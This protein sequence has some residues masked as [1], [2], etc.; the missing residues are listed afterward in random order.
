MLLQKAIHVFGADGNRVNSVDAAVAAL[1][2]LMEMAEDMTGDRAKEAVMHVLKQFSRGKSRSVWSVINNVAEVMIDRIMDAQQGKLSLNNPAAEVSDV[3]SVSASMNPRVRAV[4][5]VYAQIKKGANDGMNAADIAGLVPRVM[6]AIEATRSVPTGEEKANIAVEVLEQLADD[7][8]ISDKPA[9]KAVLTTAKAA[10]YVYSRASKGQYMLNL[11]GGAA[12]L[13]EIA[14]ETM[15]EIGDNVED[16]A[17][18]AASSCCCPSMFWKQKDVVQR[19]RVRLGMV[20][21]ADPSWGEH[22][23]L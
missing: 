17:G 5:T 3:S 16:L 1:P 7:A 6:E 11:S 23:K 20:R 18:R 19:R 2:H 10:M 8:N 14:A 21:R 4:L 15:A 12:N 9:W 13:A 22:S